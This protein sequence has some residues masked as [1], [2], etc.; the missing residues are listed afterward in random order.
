LSGSPRR[1]TVY[2][3]AVAAGVSV[4]TVSRYVAG[5]GYVGQATGARI[6]SAVARLGYVPNRAA[7]SLK[8]RRSGLIGFVVSDLQNPFVA[9]LAAGIG[10][11]ARTH[12]FGMVLADSQGQAQHTVEAIELLRSHGVDGVIVTPPTSAALNELL[13]GLH[14]QGIPVV[15][16]GL[17]SSPERIDVATVDTRSGAR[18]AVRHLVELG[19]RRIAMIGS[20]TLA[21]GRRE[22]YRQVL[23]SAKL[24]APRELMR[25]GT[26]DRAGGVAGASALL[27]LDDPPTAIFAANDAVALGVLQEASRRRVRVPRQ[28][29]LVGFD[30][31][32]LAEHAT[33]ALTTVA[34]PK[35]ELGHRAVDLLVA[36]ASGTA[37]DEPVEVVLPSELV[38]RQSTA[39]LRT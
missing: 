14:E 38:V 32:D 4:A 5:S 36:R 24:P 16:I 39:R 34:Q 18:A 19:H 37:P 11:R 7:A 29:S 1:A 15:G 31:G 22:A 2:D 20:R 28:L 13:L 9:E 17:H 33:P 3:V 27:G 25:V 35:T 6:A 26:L 8:S 12:G 23:R 10:A 30:D 21:R